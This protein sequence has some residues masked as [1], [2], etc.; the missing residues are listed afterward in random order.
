MNMTHTA[1]TL[2]GALPTHAR[3]V[4]GMGEA[5]DLPLLSLCCDSR[6][7]TTGSLFVC[8]RGATADGHRYLSAAYAAGCRC[9]LCEYLPDTPLPAD[10]VV[11]LSDDTRR[12][13]AY[14]SAAYFG[15]PARHLSIVGITGTKGKTTVAMMC[16]HIATQAGIPSG[17][18]GTLGVRYG[19]VVRTTANTTPG[20]LEH[21]FCLKV[22]WL[23]LFH[24]LPN[25]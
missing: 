11:F 22:W 18:I 19:E 21:I 16:H 15:Y 8:L 10:A 9:F 3:Q 1:R 20:A 4:H 25:H 7:A 12:D 5:A 14:L 17:Y 24:N 2:F 6:R 23:Y 13:L